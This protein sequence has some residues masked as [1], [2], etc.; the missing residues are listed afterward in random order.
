[1]KAVVWSDTIQVFLMY[2]ATICV[3]VKGISDVGGWN[4]TWQ[5]N[6]ESGRN[7]FFK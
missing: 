2:G 7:E 6:T 1:M 3:L 5:R 4:V